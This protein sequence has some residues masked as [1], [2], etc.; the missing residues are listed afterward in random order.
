MTGMRS[1]TAF[2]RR[3]GGVVL[4]ALVLSSLPA[5]AANQK[6]LPVPATT[7]SAGEVIREDAL[8]ERGFAP[9]MPGIEA[10]FDSKAFVVGRAA[11]RTLLPGQPIPTNA[12]E[13]PRVVTR[14]VPVRVV[15]EDQ[16]LMIIAYGV[17]LQSGGV[18]SL[19]RVRNVDTGVVVMG[20]VQPDGSI[21][22]SN[23]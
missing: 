10:F 19:I 22:I 4:A 20:V 16:G 13:D 15:V 14:G 2:V 8:V 1:E 5:A 17:P 12:V 23:G 18:G 9:N 21:R 7:I 6:A 11:R 3:F